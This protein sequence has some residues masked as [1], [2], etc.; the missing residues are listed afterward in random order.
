M[1]P[2]SDGFLGRSISWT[3]SNSR[4]GLC[5]CMPHEPSMS[6][7][8]SRSMRRMRP[9]ESARI[10]TLLPTAAATKSEE[11]LNCSATRSILNMGAASSSCMLLVLG[12]AYP[13]AMSYAMLRLWVK[14]VATKVSWASSKSGRQLQSTF[15][16]AVAD[17]VPR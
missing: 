15:G 8:L 16:V 2:I 10:K 1:T 7:G 12:G 3:V 13:L 4:V 5:G 9:V 14:L 17:D 11:M 6:A